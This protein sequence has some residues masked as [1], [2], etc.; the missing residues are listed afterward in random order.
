MR[1]PL[2]SK[3]RPR[4]IA[5]FLLV[6]LAPLLL[7]EY[8]NQ[9]AT[10]QALIDAAH[11]A[12]YAS[13]T[14][15]AQAIDGF[16]NE[17]LNGLR[18]HA[19]L[20]AI[21]RFL[22]APG[23]A[24]HKAAAW[25]T[26]LRLSRKDTVNLISFAVLDLA[27]HNLL[28][29]RTVQIGRDESQRDYFKALMATK[30]P[31]VSAMQFAD[32][33]GDALTLHF[34]SLVWDPAGRPLGVLRITYNATVVQ[35]LTTQALHASPSA[36]VVLLDEHHIRLADSAR[37]DLIFTSVA[38]IQMDLI[39]RLRAEWRLPEGGPAVA[40]GPPALETALK[41][42]SN[43]GYFTAPLSTGSQDAQAEPYAV[44]AARLRYRPWLVVVAEPQS[45]LLVPID[46]LLGEGLILAIAIALLVSLFGV[47]MAG[48]LTSPFRT[49]TEAVSRFSAGERGVKVA[50]PTH[51]E[52]G[53][54]ARAF[55]DMMGRIAAH[56]AEL[57]AQVAE[58][59]Q[60]LQADIARR[61]AAERALAQTHAELELRVEQ[62]TGELRAAHARLQEELAERERAE[63]EKARLE[64]QLRQ[65][66][67]LEAIGTLAGGIAHDF[68]NILGAIL[69]YA[70]MALDAVPEGS[71]LKRYV[72]NVMAAANRAKDLVDQI[73]AFTQPGSRE[74]VPVRLGPLLG[75]VAE[76]IKAS[77]PET[78]EL[79]LRVNAEDATVQ[80][81]VIRLHQLVM[82]VCTNAVQ[83]MPEGGL[84]KIALDVIELSERM[85]QRHHTIEPGAYVRL[86]VTDTGHGIDEAT[87]DRVFDPFFT[88]KDLGRGTGLGL[89]LVHSIVSD[90]GGAIEVS[91]TPGQ[92]SC[93]TVYLPR[94]LE[95]AFASGIERAPIPS[96]RGE[97]VLLVDDDEALV[98]LGE[99]M[100]AALGY[101]PIGFQ[102]SQAALE[103]FQ[104][105]PARFD[106]VVTDQLMPRMS[107]TELATRLREIRPDIPVLLMSGF[108]GPEL[109]HKA[110]RAAVHALLKKP[111]QSRDLAQAIASA[112][113]VNKKFGADS[114]Q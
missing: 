63:S 70:E 94:S 74:R 41:R 5:A 71:N 25:Q 111:L 113:N 68:N 107:G 104:A 58:R 24:L 67:K 95:T 73:L 109:A 85:V 47:G 51:D 81:D 35:Q 6:S 48:R 82:N 72:G 22:S 56:T 39:R 79:K 110:Q 60:A 105:R 53:E 86:K 75:E 77:L 66:Q 18:V 34:A 57:E 44:G 40:T 112:L 52:A 108:G 62:R 101:E 97:T 96:G 54:L 98:L 88:T 46:R 42:L 45:V 14:Q 83:A 4:L 26:L 20:P 59:T 55:N 64:A 80:G 50:V 103:A 61:E 84:L 102:D 33:P 106:L 16:L 76:L 90:H 91:S 7:L 23:D 38:P 11:R 114:R 89:S 99:E 28:D 10:R 30:V 21:Q 17:N 100:I 92:G 15:T 1:R 37:P 69:G 78:I 32:A 27:G 87:L 19:L 36:R 93:F 8:F 29:T 31:T 9:R 12:L 3:L 2:F 65:A 43:G 13:A 49:L